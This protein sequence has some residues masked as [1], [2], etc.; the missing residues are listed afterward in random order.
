MLFT[1]LAKTLPD[2]AKD[3]RL[4]VSSLVT[5]QTLS[6]Q[7]KWGTIVACAHATACKP[8][9]D[10]AEEEAADKISPEAM[11]A[12]KA[13]AS[14]MAM[15]NIYYRFTHL[16]SRQD[17]RTMPA[18]LRMNVIGSPGIEKADFELYSLA[19]S[20]IN[21]CGMCIDSHDK[22]LAG[23]GMA[24]EKIHTAARIASVVHAVARTL[25]AM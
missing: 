11:N 17:Y 13:A 1:E 10:A 4:N 7:Q 24:V 21:G 18:K 22:V 9:I 19:V 5:E 8:L 23:H 15:N 16:A 2:Y 6:D 20:A 14:I 25:Q 12:A 3:L